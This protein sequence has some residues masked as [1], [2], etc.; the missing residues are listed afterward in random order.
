[1]PPAAGCDASSTYMYNHLLSIDL[2][3]QLLYVNPLYMCL[4]TLRLVNGKPAGPLLASYSNAQCK[5]VKSKG[6]TIQHNIY[7]L[8]VYT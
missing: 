2:S 5:K 7:S 1:M 8:V 4:A 6:S 3:T